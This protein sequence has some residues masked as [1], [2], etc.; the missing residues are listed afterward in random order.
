MGKKANAKPSTKAKGSE[1]TVGKLAMPLALAAALAAAVYRARTPPLPEPVPR[2]QPAS[3]LAARIV[4]PWRRR[5]SE[6]VQ[7]V[8]DCLKQQQQLTYIPATWPGFHALCVESSAPGELVVRAL[9][10]EDGAARTVRGASVRAVLDALQPILASDYGKDDPT[11][12]DSVYAYPPHPW[13]LFSPVGEHITD[14][15]AQ[16]KAG[17]LACVYEGG[18]FIWPGWAIGHV[19]NIEVPVVD[20][21]THE[22]AWRVVPITTV[23]LRPLAFELSGFLTDDECELIID[24]A[25]KRLVPSGLAHMDATNKADTDVRTSTQTFMERGGVRWILNLEHRAH[26]L[27]RLPYALG[28]NIQVVKYEK[29]QKYGAHRDFFSANDYQQQPAMCAR[30]ASRA[31]SRPSR[32]VSCGGRARSWRC[33][34]L[35]LCLPPPARPPRRASV[36]PVRAPF[37]LARIGRPPQARLGGVRRAQPPRHALLVLD[38]RAGGR[39]NLFPARAQRERRRVQPVE[40]R[41]RGLLPR[42]RRAAR[43]QERRALLQPAAQRPP[44]RAQPAR[45]VQA[46][47]RA[48]RSQMGRK[49]MDLYA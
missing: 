9:V 48:D 6:S 2:A 25:A 41:P 21:R 38:F 46:A 15:G 43:A 16:L 28:E 13:E 4:H 14:G 17:D 7:S 49:P 31:R 37:S 19:T 12:V 34:S 18:Q 42:A 40:R 20:A 47:R 36:R 33:R 22:E 10:R 8:D 24:Y 30:A 26:N 3:A 11:I 32:S 27:T 39:R 23:S 35:L 45:R 5:M 29:G 1:G 44:R